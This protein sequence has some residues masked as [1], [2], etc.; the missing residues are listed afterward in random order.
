[1]T[2]EWNYDQYIHGDIKPSATA[3][4]YVKEAKFIMNMLPSAVVDWTETDCFV[5][6]VS[7]NWFEYWKK[8]VSYQKLEDGMEYGPQSIDMEA[9]LPVLNLDL[10]DDSYDS[11]KEDFVFL[12]P[13]SENYGLFSVVTKSTISETNDYIIIREE[14]W[15]KVKGFYPDAKE[16][17]RLKYTDQTTGYSKVEVKFP[18]VI[19]SLT[20]RF[21]ATFCLNQ[22][23]NTQARQ[24]NSYKNST[25]YR[26][27]EECKL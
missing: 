21:H 2:T 5:Y 10:I 13:K 4:D 12:K 17:K 6:L 3:E 15:T 27:L 1:M 26:Y 22:S 23:L 14:A 9:N 7:T 18:I 8:K 16:I 24:I 25:S 11:N 20:S 19:T